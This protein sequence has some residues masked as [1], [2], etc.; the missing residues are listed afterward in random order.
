MVNADGT[1]R[2]ASLDELPDGILALIL[3][4]LALHEA[5]SVRGVSRSLRRLVEA[6]DWSHL[7]VA[8][9]NHERLDQLA[10]LLVG[11]G[12][13][14]S[15]AVGPGGR[16]VRVAPGASL[17]VVV[18]K[19]AQRPEPAAGRPA[20]SQRSTWEA[21]LSLISASNAASG[22]LSSVEVESELG[23][24][25]Q[26]GSCTCD[27]LSALAPPGGAAAP[28]LRSFIFRKDSGL[29]GGRPGDLD[30]SPLLR[31]FPSLSTLALP[32]CWSVGTGAAND[33]LDCLPRLKRLEISAPSCM[34]FSPI[35]K[36]SSLET[37]EIRADKASRDDAFYYSLRSA[38][39]TL[40]ASAAARSLRTLR[41]GTTTRC[42]F[43]EE[44]LAALP[45]FASL[46]HFG[47]PLEISSSIGARD[48]AD[49]LASCPALRSFGPVWLYPST[50]NFLAGF[51]SALERSPL[52]ALDIAILEP[53]PDHAAALPS[54]AALALAA[55][56]G[57]LDLCLWLDLPLGRLAET[58]AALAA[59]PPRRLVLYIVP[60]HGGEAPGYRIAACLSPF[61]SCAL[62][63]LEVRLAPNHFMSLTEAVL[64]AAAGA[65][66]SAR[67]V[68]SMTRVNLS[69]T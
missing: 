59:A 24:P 12:G 54:L 16:W 46:E 13:E 32:T 57:R 42:K 65:L 19:V 15:S 67:I 60:D 51:A 11:G 1:A 64:E 48:V 55:R 44:S 33:I 30:I 36:L 14:D 26:A 68:S 39:P 35:G 56:G 38:L 18:K 10:A 23:C 49:A 37:L 2:A 6:R 22:G 21:A 29:C 4:Q 50:L 52:L 43:G 69:A 41:C 25:S 20:E 8:A 47:G 31:P 58:A 45:R 63:H 40:A 66:P 5:S 53:I 28:Q 3:G 27:V 62:Q 34:D 61:A 9:S 7:D 17:R